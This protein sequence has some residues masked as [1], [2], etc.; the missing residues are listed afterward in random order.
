MNDI[1]ALAASKE[2]LALTQA[3]RDGKRIHNLAKR[4]GSAVASV[5]D[6]QLQEALDYVLLVMRNNKGRG[7]VV[8]QRPDVVY[9]VASAAI[10]SAEQSRGR[11]NVAWNTGSLLGN[12]VARRQAKLWGLAKPKP[13]SPDTALLQSLQTDVEV[14][15]GDVREAMIQ[16]ILDEDEEALQKAVSK[17]VLR[18][19]MSG[20]AAAKF[21]AQGA[22]SGALESAGG[23]Y[24]KWMTTSAL[25]CSHCL[26]LA[27]HPAILW[28]EEFPHAFDGLPEL[29]VYGGKLMGPPRHPNCACVLVAV[30]EA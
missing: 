15:A 12:A 29:K 28:S 24:K 4:H 21:G 1:V 18:S 17:V 8:A 11:L 30:K 23:L 25:P 7:K 3:Q 22:L 6:A 19:R 26:T 27:A 13:F 20:E 2:Q 10:S 16:A 5:W 14:M 9:A